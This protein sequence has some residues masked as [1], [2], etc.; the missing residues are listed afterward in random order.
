MLTPNEVNIRLE[1]TSGAMR[2]SIN[3]LSNGKYRLEFTAYDRDG[4][5]VA[6]KSG[7]RIV[8]NIEGLICK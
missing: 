6:Y 2:V 4:Y 8:D 5:Y 3:R 7:T 1:S